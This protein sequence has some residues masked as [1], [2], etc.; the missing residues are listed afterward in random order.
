MTW[1]VGG[2]ALQAEALRIEYVWEVEERQKSQHA[3][4]GKIGGKGGRWERYLGG[5]RSYLGLE[6]ICKDW[7][8]DLSREVV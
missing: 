8:Q 4:P 1:I 3:G 2:R 6:D 5:G 7:E